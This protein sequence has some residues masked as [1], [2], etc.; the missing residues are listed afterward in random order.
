VTLIDK[1]LSK[2]LLIQSYQIKMGYLPMNKIPTHLKIGPKQFSIVT[3]SNL[4]E[5]TETCKTGGFFYAY[6]D[7]WLDFAIKNKYYEEYILWKSENG[8][9]YDSSASLSSVKIDPNSLNKESNENNNVVT[10][11][12]VFIEPTY[13][14]EVEM[15]KE[16]VFEVANTTNFNPYLTPIMFTV[17][18]TGNQGIVVVLEEHNYITSTDGKNLPVYIENVAGASPNSEKTITYVLDLIDYSKIG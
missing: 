4:I 5:N 9:Y 10:Q 1:K 18:N 17:K 16:Y 13:D 6:R 3:Y 11:N 15:D 12:V 2:C 7:S 8:Y 14:F